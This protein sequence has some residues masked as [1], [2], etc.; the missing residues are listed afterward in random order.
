M[1]TPGISDIIRMSIL[2]EDRSE[3]NK[4]FKSRVEDV[5]ENS[6]T[7]EI[8]LDENNGKVRAFPIGTELSC[9]YWGPDGSRY[10]FRSTVLRRENGDFPTI[11][12][13]FPPKESIQR[14]QRRNYLRVPASVEVAVKGTGEKL[15]HFIAKTQDVSGGGIAISCKEQYLIQ[16]GNLLNCWMVVPLRSGLEYIPFVG[17]V[18]RVTQ[19]K[20]PG[21]EQTVSLM[22]K[23]IKEP[24]REKLIR[25]CYE[26]QRAMRA[27]GIL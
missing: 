10:L 4:T 13:S 23:Q 25:Y 11:T 3:A 20:V 19:P 9:Y 27:K 21:G 8:P 17:K 16:V 14:I 1:L 26:R 12:I 18:V 5:Q 15:Y 7:I 24:D 6:L 2:T 22:F